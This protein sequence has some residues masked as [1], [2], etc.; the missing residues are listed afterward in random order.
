[1]GRTSVRKTGEKEEGGVEQGEQRVGGMG[2]WEGVK[3]DGEEG[4]RKE[5]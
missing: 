5:G 2:V 4:R 3:R 1:M